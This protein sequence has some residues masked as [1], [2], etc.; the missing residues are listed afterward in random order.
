ILSH[1]AGAPCRQSTGNQPRGYVPQVRSA[2][3]IRR[4]QSRKHRWWVVVG[5]YPEFIITEQLLFLGCSP[6]SA[7][8]RGSPHSCEIHRFVT[9]LSQNAAKSVCICRKGGLE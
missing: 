7:L 8:V 3:S 5:S 4:N 1:T 9:V 2:L 6:A